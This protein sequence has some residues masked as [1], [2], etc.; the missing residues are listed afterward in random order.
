MIEVTHYK[1]VHQ[2]GTKEYSIYLFYS[3]KTKKALLVRRWGKVGADGQVKV[4]SP[5]GNGNKALD[6]LL[7]ER[8]AKGYDMR[9]AAHLTGTATV[10]D[11]VEDALAVL[12]RQHRRTFYISQLSR[13][14]PDRFDAKLS[15]N[16]DPM[17]GD[18][19]KVRQELEDARAQ[20]EREIAL[21][22]AEESDAILKSNPFYGMF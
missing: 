16:F 20:K 21:R 4:E 6:A 5:D 22:E 14:D 1:G 7:D 12:P 3:Q 8:R 10:Y 11:S 15:G 18:R 13:L 2:G 17:A 19:D 9:L